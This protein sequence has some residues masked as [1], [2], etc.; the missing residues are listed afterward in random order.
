MR[1]Q[2]DP[3]VIYEITRGQY[4]LDRRL[5]FQDLSKKGDYNTYQKDGL[6]IG[7][8]NNP[9]RSSIIATLNPAKTD[10]LYFVLKPSIGI[11]V[12]SKDY[13]THTKNS[14]E[15]LSTNN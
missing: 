10:Y 2:T 5:N 14:V 3:T 9:S 8:I 15:Y 4:K 1:L 12:F 13:N 11:H 6:P 7:P